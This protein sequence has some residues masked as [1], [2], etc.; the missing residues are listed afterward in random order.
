MI[1]ANILQFQIF[2]GREA[3]HL[4]D[5]SYLLAIRAGSGVLTV[6]GFPGI[7][8]QNKHAQ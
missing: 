7:F 5:E 6:P 3:E 1:T 8:F 2:G 4:S